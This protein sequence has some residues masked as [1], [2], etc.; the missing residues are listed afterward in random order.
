MKTLRERALDEHE[1]EFVERLGMSAQADGLTRIAGRIWAV[2]MLTDVPL[3]AARLAE[4]LTISKG[5]ISTN[6][7][8]LESLD[9]INRHFIAGA[10][11]EHFAIQTNAYRALVEGQIKRFETSREF[12]A[13]SRKKLRTDTAKSRLAELELFYQLFEDGCKTV[14]AN[15]DKHDPAN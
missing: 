7:R 15:M 10:R 14:I 12:L 1:S 8:V 11:Q 3:S 4:L 2:L 13:D 5:S 6:T 9:I